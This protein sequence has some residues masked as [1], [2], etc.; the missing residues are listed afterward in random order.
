VIRRPKNLENNLDRLLRIAISI[1]LDK[2][3]PRIHADLH[4]IPCIS[5]P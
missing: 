4:G 3:R 2:S 5:N 1:S